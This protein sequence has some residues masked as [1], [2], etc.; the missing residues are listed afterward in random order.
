VNALD[1][2]LKSFLSLLTLFA[3]LA[4]SSC[5]SDF[6]IG[7]W[8]MICRMPLLVAGATGHVFPT[9]FVESLLFLLPFC[10][11]ATTSLSKRRSFRASWFGQSSLAVFVQ[12]MERSLAGLGMLVFASCEIVL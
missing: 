4:A 7:V 5:L 10:C 9:G 6:F 12:Q 1:I 11:A 8:A 2:F 3:V